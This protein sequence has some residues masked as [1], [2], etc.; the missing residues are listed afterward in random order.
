MHHIHGNTV[1]LWM[2]ISW[3]SPLCCLPAGSKRM[4]AGGARYQ[5]A[6]LSW[7][8]PFHQALPFPSLQ[9]FPA[10]LLES[11]TAISERLYSSV[12]WRTPLRRCALSH[13]HYC[14]LRFFSTHELNCGVM[15]HSLFEEYMCV[16][17]KLKGIIIQHK[18]NSEP[19]SQ[20]LP[21]CL[22]FVYG[23]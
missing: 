4:T 22:C 16:R 21:A 18:R 7:L 8:K 13:E 3:N 2:L 23:G 9:T 1:P 15:A 6:A 12:H 11:V 17:L 19:Q 20:W 5:R 14:S 10:N